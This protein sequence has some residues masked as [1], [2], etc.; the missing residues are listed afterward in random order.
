MESKKLPYVMYWII[1]GVGILSFSM[2]FFQEYGIITTLILTFLCSLFSLAIA[3]G[4]GKRKFVYLSILLL[5]SPWLYLLS[6][7][8]IN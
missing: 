6:K 2:P 7:N 8:L 1:L 3:M 5:V 4:L